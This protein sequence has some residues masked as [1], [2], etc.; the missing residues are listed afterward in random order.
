MP[1]TRSKASRSQARREIQY[2]KNPENK[3]NLA[4]DARSDCSSNLKTKLAITPKTVQLLQRCGCKDYRDLRHSSPNQI[5][6]QFKELSGITSSQ[7]ETYRRGLRRMVW[8]ATKDNPE[9]LAK[10]HQNWS[11]KA[12]TAR[13]WWGDGY[14]DMTGDQ[15]HQHIDRV[16]N[17]KVENVKG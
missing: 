5:V 8:L 14:D 1:P 13:G 16:E 6:A 12:L 10:I 4:A 15:A 9:E 2:H 17:V 3:S 7:A 11:Q